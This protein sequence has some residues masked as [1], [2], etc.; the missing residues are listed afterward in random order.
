MISVILPEGMDPATGYKTWITNPAT[1]WPDSPGQNSY[2]SANEYG[3]VWIAQAI[4]NGMSHADEQERRDLPVAARDVGR[5]G[6]SRI[7]APARA[8]GSPT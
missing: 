2:T 7:S 6:Q 4:N 5:N 8:N 1:N 3:P